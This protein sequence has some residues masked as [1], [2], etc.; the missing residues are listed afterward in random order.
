[1]TFNAG[2]DCGGEDIHLPVHSFSE[3]LLSSHYVLDTFPGPVCYGEQGTQDPGSQRAR[4]KVKEA[5]Y[6]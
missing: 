3:N 1:M 6:A 2:G 5:A 4:I